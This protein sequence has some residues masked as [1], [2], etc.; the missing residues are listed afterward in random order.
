MELDTARPWLLLRLWKTGANL[1]VQE[2]LV[3]RR[4]GERIALYLVNSLKLSL[5]I[6]K[7]RGN[8][9]ASSWHWFVELK[10][11]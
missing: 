4:K 5:A 3:R 8:Y 2:L 6:I 7:G 9:E 1:A 10:C 11:I